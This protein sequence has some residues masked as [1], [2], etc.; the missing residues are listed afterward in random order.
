MH[1]HGTAKAD[2]CEASLVSPV[3]G[4]GWLEEE[5][6]RS[7]SVVLQVRVSVSAEELAAALYSDEYLS[8]ADLAADAHVWG[9]AAV[10]VVQSGLDTVER[11]VAE[12]KTAEEQG[13]LANPDWLATCRRRVAD[14]TRSPASQAHT[15]LP[16]HS[17]GQDLE[18]MKTSRPQ[19]AATH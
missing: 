15:P 12:I 9:C 2:Q 16:G 10:A 13:A 18:R 8:P 6:D 11:R 14:V 3:I 4:R 5:G 1:N 17:I 19:R 7:R